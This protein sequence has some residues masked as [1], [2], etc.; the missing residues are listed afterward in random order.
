[1]LA[2]GGMGELGLAALAKKTGI[3]LKTEVLRDLSH[4]N[5]STTQPPLIE[6]VSCVAWEMGDRLAYV[7]AV[8][9][10]SSVIVIGEKDEERGGMTF[11]APHFS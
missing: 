4:F 6:V 9:I 1:M 3:E 11:T 8:A 7:F 5:Q 10:G 2:A